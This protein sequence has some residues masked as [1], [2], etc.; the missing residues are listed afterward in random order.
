MKLAELLFL[1]GTQKSQIPFP[2]FSMSFWL[3]LAFHIW[4][5]ALSFISDELNVALLPCSALPSSTPIPA[6]TLQFSFLPTR[7]D[8]GG[9]S[10]ST[11]ASCGQWGVGLSHCL[12][13]FIFM[14]DFLDPLSVGCEEHHS[15]LTWA[16]PLEY[17]LRNC[18][19]V[20]HSFGSYS[21][22]QF[23]TIRKMSH[24]PCCCCFH[25]WV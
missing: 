6:I 11:D 23:R 8:T 13:A 9:R 21:W 14:G 12:P 17:R 7:V 18:P 16:L 2:N 10:V 1:I 19:S 4:M 25:M 24:S 5:K 3:K 22:H 20:H 15:R